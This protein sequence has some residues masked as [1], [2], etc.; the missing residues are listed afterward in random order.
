MAK[1]S[2]LMAVYNAAPYLRR[3][4]DTLL[5][6]TQADFQVVCID[7]ASTDDSPALL[8]E[9]AH[10]D[11]RIEVIHLAEN[12]GAAQARQAGLQLATA[13]LIAFLDSDDWLS[14][15]ALELA[16][17]TFDDHTETD[18][19][20]FHLLMCSTTGKE[21]PYPIDEFESLPGEKAFERRINWQGIHGCGVFRREVYDR[22]L[23]DHSNASFADENMTRLRLYYSREV[24]LCAGTYYYYETPTSVTR[25]ISVRR[26]D[27]L[28]NNES[29]AQ[30]IHQ[31]N[32]PHAIVCQQENLRYLKLIDVYM[33]YHHHA[34]ELSAEEQ[35]Y[36]LN[37]M[38]RIWQGIDRSLLS[39]TLTRKFGYCPMPSWRLFR[40]QEW[41]Y[42]TLRSILR[43][44]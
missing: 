23:T 43:S 35:R 26:F 42:F 30:V 39:P 16:C 18:C 33:L 29:L 32:M 2:V 6:Q 12:S 9:Y 28:R 19:V 37:E 20:L 13:P 34:H 25:S 1:I 40:L 10:R 4:L 21:Q 31:L 11:N 36:A 38:R 15:D 41:L 44:K 14:D 17:R 8:E 22:V 24:R 3:S 7:D 27:V 5:S